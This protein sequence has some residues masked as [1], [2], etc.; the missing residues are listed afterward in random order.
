M[1]RVE[2]VFDLDS[3]YDDRV[4]R[5]Y[6]AVYTQGRCRFGACQSKLQIQIRL[7]PRNRVCHRGRPEAF[8][9]SFK[10]F[11]R[12][13]ARYRQNLAWASAGISQ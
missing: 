7:D 10:R 3:K 2:S 6:E 9:L 11:H 12:P 8:H 4:L 13:T 1:Q 5:K